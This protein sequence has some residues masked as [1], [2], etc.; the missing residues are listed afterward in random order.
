MKDSEYGK[1]LILTL[2]ETMERWNLLKTIG[3]YN[4]LLGK[5]RK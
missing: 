3:D 1:Q 5:V 4:L 2:N